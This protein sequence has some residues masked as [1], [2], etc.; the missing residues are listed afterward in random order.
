MTDR[1]SLPLAECL[2]YARTARETGVVVR[3]AVKGREFTFLPEIHSQSPSVPVD[4]AESFES[5][6][7]YK[8][9]RDGKDARH[10]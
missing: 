1:A 5:L 10:D 2:R 4:A 9:W 6:D 7:D 3:V 8:A